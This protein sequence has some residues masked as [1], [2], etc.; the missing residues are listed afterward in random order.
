MKFGITHRESLG[1]QNLEN[2]LKKNE[3]QRMNASGLPI[4]RQEDA[5]NLKTKKGTAGA[6]RGWCEE[7]IIMQEEKATMVLRYDD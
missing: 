4:K 3:E 1:P 7:T 5:P 6:I 2:V